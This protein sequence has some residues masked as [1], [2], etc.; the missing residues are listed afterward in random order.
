LLTFFQAA[1]IEF[2]LLGVKYMGKNND[3]HGGC[4]VNMASGAGIYP[5][6]IKILEIHA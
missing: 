1:V 2:T 6:N 4:I 5:L 3:G